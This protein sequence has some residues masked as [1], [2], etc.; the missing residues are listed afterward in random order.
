MRARF[1][2]QMRGFHTPGAPAYDA[3]YVTGLRDWNRI[4]FQLTIGSDDLAA[5]LDDP[6]HPMTATGWLRCTALSASDLPVQAG[7]F[8]L[9]SPGS[10]RQ[11]HL[12]RYRLPVQTPDGPMT[13]L[14]FKMVGNDRG[15]DLWPD[16]TTLYTRIVHGDADFDA[17]VSSEYSRGILR[18]N[19]AMFSR[20]MLTFRG[21][22]LGLARF[23][24]FFGRQLLRTYARRPRT[25]VPG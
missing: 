20:Q 13:L 23:G 9:F 18:L 11:R 22:P 12:M 3:G 15:F 16:T 4:G 6:L 24:A 25:E 17:P 7:T 5:M 10:S 19:L 2:E 1:T 8:N 21:T 14:G